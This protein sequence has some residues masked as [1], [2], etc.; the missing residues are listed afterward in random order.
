[1]QISSR[2]LAL[3]SVLKKRFGRMSLSIV[4]PGDRFIHFFLSIRY[5]TS[6]TDQL[7]L[8]DVK[9]AVDDYL[10]DIFSK[11]KVAASEISVSYE[12]FWQRVEQ[13]AME[14]GKRFRPYLTMVGYGSMNS[15]LLPIAAAQECIHCA[16]LMH[17]DVIDQDFIRRG[18]KNV[19]GLYRDVYSSYL[20]VERAEHY[21]NSAGI[22]AGDA[23]LSEAYFQ[24]Y[25]SEFSEKIKM[26]L[27]EQL[28]LST[29][30]VVGGELT[31]VESAFVH[32]MPFDP[33]KIYRYK[34]AGY[35]FVGPL[36]SGAYCHEES[37]DTID[38]LRRYAISAGI[39]FQIHDDLL[40]VFG[41][42]R[43]TGKSTLTDLREGKRT[44]LVLFHEKQMQGAAVKRFEIFSRA[45]ATDEQLLA[46][47]DDMIASGARER[48]SEI[49]DTYFSEAK[50]ELAG[51]P[52][53]PRRLA[54]EELT[55]WLAGRKH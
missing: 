28:F 35:S 10:R 25:R 14:G 9:L 29:Y 23:L 3:G 40:G 55:E 44:L 4:L 51:M 15:A 16:M 33:I 7:S 22:L 31:D 13:V 32:D 52:E 17:D 6:M 12:K 18:N 45:D 11:R 20:D 8:S 26:Q 30:E 21:A 24:I 53:S 36:L 42:E 47:K 34:T 2:T 1:M 39:A 38:S 19:N 41:D 37:Q 46:I 50:Q 27:A 48:V 54:L 5:N 49:A 43:E